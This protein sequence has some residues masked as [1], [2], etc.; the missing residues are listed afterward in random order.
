MA[1]QIKAWY[2]NMSQMEMKST[3]LFK[4]H[5]NIDYWHK[6]LGEC[7]E[8]TDGFTKPFSKR[9]TLDGV[10]VEITWDNSWNIKEM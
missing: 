3:I 4:Y 10:S 9:C 1:R 7:F 2:M 5:K 8:E 6:F